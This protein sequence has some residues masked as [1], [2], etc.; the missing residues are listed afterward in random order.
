LSSFL[1]HVITPALAIFDFFF[2][3]YRISL[4]K[5]HLFASLIPLFAY[6]LFVSILI[7]LKVDF[8][9][10]DPYPYIFLNYYSPAGFFGFSDQMPYIFGSFYWFLIILSLVFGLGRL[11]QRITDRLI[12]K[13]REKSASNSEKEEP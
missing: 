11:Y 2:D 8:G 10:G 4:T 6:L 13:Q 9:R 5:R 3:K 1:T 12:G 7:L